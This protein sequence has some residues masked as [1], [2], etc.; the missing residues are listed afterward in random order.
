MWRG[1]R[2]CRKCWGVSVSLLLRRPWL[3]GCPFLRE[4]AQVKEPRK[5]REQEMDCSYY[6]VLHSLLTRLSL[7]LPREPR[8]PKV[9]TCVGVCDGLIMC[10]FLGLTVY[11]TLTVSNAPYAVVIMAHVLGMSTET[12]RVVFTCSFMDLFWRP[13]IVIVCMCT[14]C[15]CNS[16][17]VYL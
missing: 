4:T 6:P 8:L 2:S 10:I 12:C 13:V 7:I 9:S 17:C 3:L 1:G 14:L 11:K 15:E 5:V 16:S